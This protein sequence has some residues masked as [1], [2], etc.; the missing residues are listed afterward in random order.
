MNN[1][2]MK[3]SLFLLHKCCFLSLCPTNNTGSYPTRTTQSLEI[4][5]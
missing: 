3:H 1:F 2:P 4:E 5:S